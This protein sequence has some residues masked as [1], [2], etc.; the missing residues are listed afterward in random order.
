MGYTLQKHLIVWIL[1][2]SN[3]FDRNALFCQTD[4][5]VSIPYPISCTAAHHS[6][7]KPWIMKENRFVIIWLAKTNSKVFQNWTFKLS[8]VIWINTGHAGCWCTEVS[9]CFMAFTSHTEGS[10]EL[11]YL[12]YLPP[13]VKKV[14]TTTLPTKHL[15]KTV[16]WGTW[17]T[18]M[19][20][21]SWNQ[22]AHFIKTKIIYKQKK[23]RPL[24]K[25]W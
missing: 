21:P 20:S 16:I 7:E 15:E 2:K 6:H 22:M 3:W 8:T 25:S 12:K 17:A 5:F 1:P 14:H 23:P 24:T 9:I 19:V 18:S 4:G 10:Q 11:F 13:R